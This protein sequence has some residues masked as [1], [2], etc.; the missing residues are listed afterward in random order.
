MAKYKTP[1]FK[2]YSLMFNKKIYLHLIKCFNFESVLTLV[3]L[4]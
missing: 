4:K 2:I 3:H 1:E